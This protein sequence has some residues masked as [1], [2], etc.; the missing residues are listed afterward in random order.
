MLK[1]SI[2]A[3]NFITKIS[4]LLL[5]GL[6]SCLIYAQNDSN[7]IYSP[8][9]AEIMYDKGF[10]LTDS[11]D[12]F[13]KSLVFY[14]SA[15]RADPQANYFL[16]DMIQTICRNSSRDNSDLVYSLLTK[17]V[18]ESSD[19]EITN[20]AVAYLLENLNTREQ[21]E[22]MLIDLRKD[23]GKRND[24]LDSELCVILGMLKYETADKDAAAGL[25]MEA[26]TKNPFN[27][28]AFE[29]IA[30]IQ[31]QAI[32]AELELIHLRNMVTKNP[33]DINR[34][35]AFAKT[36]LRYQ[37]YQIANNAYNYSSELFRYLQPDAPL[38]E[39][40]YLPHLLAAYNTDKNYSQCLEIID[41]V[42]KDGKFNLIAEVIAA[43]SARQIG[44][45]EL[46]DNILENAEAKIA[47][48][49]DSDTFDSK[50]AGWFYLFGKQ[51]PQKALKYANKAYAEA[52][53]NPSAAGILAYSLLL[54]DQAKWAEP[55]LEQYTHSPVSMLAQASIYLNQNEKDKAVETLKELIK[56]SPASIEAVKAKKILK[57]N[58]SEYIQSEQAN[59]IRK[60]MEGEFGLDIVPQFVPIHKALAL[61]FKTKGMTFAYASDFEGSLIITNTSKM[62]MYIGEQNLIRGHIRIDAKVSGDMERDF[63]KL[64]SKRVRPA[65]P[66]EPGRSLVIPLKLKQKKLR[67]L[68]TSH[69]QAKFEINL[70]GYIDPVQNENSKVQNSITGLPPAEAQV[71]RNRV[72]LTTKYLQNRLNSL[73]KSKP[74]SGELFVGLL[75]EQQ[76]MAN[77]E[78]AY[79]FRYAEWM[80]ELLRSAIEQTLVQDGPVVKVQTLLK[81][82]NMH[83]NYRL[84][85]AVAECLNSDNA[86]VRLS[87]VYVLG[88]S[89]QKGFDKVLEHTSKYDSSSIVR[90]MAAVMAGISSDM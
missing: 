10:E 73:S 72:I 32:T 36:A 40:I 19:L 80:P 85:E 35:T 70:T 44:N 81:M 33:Y 49:S 69:P 59:F 55:L 41:K 79:R 67:R 11:D 25:F 24:P 62:N 45:P 27:S 87:A 7:E 8:T 3:L 34:I 47:D 20:T 75:K 78:P 15:L 4:L 48:L 37:L 1:K 43:K 12:Q 16:A 6:N 9:I 13:E 65:G 2:Y 46:A 58:G 76:L 89:N 61:D 86:F 68:L 39:E 22:K 74:K 23:V 90:E 38:P 17:Y 21:R 5:A 29:K 77:K 26:Y 83:L 53:N 52:P 31:P 56:A 60:M 88:L 51:A 64:I 57:E 71:I 50:Q 30:Q 42:R 18:T 14:K 82:N 84:T 28:K 63:P 66:V 54:N